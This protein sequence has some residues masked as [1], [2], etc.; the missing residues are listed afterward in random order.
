MSAVRRR[1]RRTVLRPTSDPNLD[2]ALEAMTAPELRS[3]VRT[4]FD[5]LDDDQRIT[6]TD[7]LMARATQGK[8]GWKSSLPSARLVEEVGVFADAARRVAYADPDEVSDYLRQS[9]TPLSRRANAV[10]SAVTDVAGVVLLANPIED[11]EG[12]S[13]GALPDLGSF[14][15]RWVK[16]LERVRPAKDDWDSAPDRWVREAVFR[17][18]GVDGLERL[19]RK[20]KRPRACLA[21]CEALAEQGAWPTA[22]RA[23]DDAAKLVGKSPWRGELIDGAALAAQQLGRSDVGTRLEA[24]WAGAP[25]LA[26][27]RVAAEKRIDG[28]LGQSRRRHYGHAATLAASCLAAAPKDGQQA[29]SD[30]IAR[31]STDRWPISRVISVCSMPMQ[32]LRSPVIELRNVLLIRGLAGRRRSFRNTPSEFASSKKT[33]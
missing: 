27:L 1:R 16:R 12:V 33:R 15:P 14:L 30:W 10:Y 31:R 25:S 18:E 8:A 19:A 22:L 6:I 20:T 28:I 21:W 9:S 4:V 26:R 23:Y 32:S 29:A 3:F 7:S 11:M 24:A 17:L 5:S 13:A 2:R